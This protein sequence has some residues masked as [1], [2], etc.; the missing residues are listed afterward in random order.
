MHSLYS[1]MK[2]MKYK[3]H[4]F[5]SQIIIFTHQRIQLKVLLLFYIEAYSTHY[6]DTAS[7]KLSPC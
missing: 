2:Y 3:G 4:I 1:Y 7:T 5:I 6:I